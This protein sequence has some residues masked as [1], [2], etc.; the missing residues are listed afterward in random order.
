MTDVHTDTLFFKPLIC[1]NKDS[2]SLCICT[3]IKA[4][5]TKEY[6]YSYLNMQH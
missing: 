5:I 4:C 3:K 1:N 6:E 2:V